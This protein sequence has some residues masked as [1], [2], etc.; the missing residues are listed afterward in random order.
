MIGKILLWTITLSCIYVI[1]CV[2]LNV[3]PTVMDIQNAVQ[4]NN[5]LL[6]LSY[7]YFAGLIFYFLVSFYPFIK[8]KK[9]FTPIINGKKS[10]LFNQVEAC[11]QTFESKEVKGVVNTISKEELISLISK[12][13]MYANSYYAINVGYQMNNLQFLVNTK[14]NCFNIIDRMIVYKEYLTAN[15]AYC[16]EKIRDSSFFHLTKVYE[17]T[18]VAKIYYNSTQFK[19]ELA[20]ELY[21][22]ILQTRAI[23]N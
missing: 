23:C 7:S 12:S 5:V 6:N 17:S 19:H 11:I 10:D 15:D 22:I 8:Q 16:L 9:K 1:G 13:D 3:F 4:I 21:E 2:G 14:S 20:N 18:P